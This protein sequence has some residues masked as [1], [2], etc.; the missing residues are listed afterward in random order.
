[1]PNSERLVKETSS[2]PSSIGPERAFIG[3]TYRANDIMQLYRITDRQIWTPDVEL[4]LGRRRE[5][6]ENDCYAGAISY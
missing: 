1:M 4:R 3:Q 2:S 5:A 6:A